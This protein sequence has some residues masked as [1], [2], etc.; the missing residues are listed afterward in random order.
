MRFLRLKKPREAEV[1]DEW[2]NFLSSDHYIDFSALHKIL[3]LICSRRECRSGT[4]GLPSSWPSP[5]GEKERY[6]QG[7]GNSGEE[8]PAQPYP[9]RG[10]PQPVSVNLKKAEAP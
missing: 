8:G 10:E 3:F 9:A 7:S 1:R 5:A 6:G 4:G 2:D